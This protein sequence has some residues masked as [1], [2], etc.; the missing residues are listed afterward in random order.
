[1]HIK[2]NNFKRALECATSALHI[3]ENNQKAKFREAQ[4]R[5]GLGEIS[6]GRQMLEELQKK[7]P[8][9]AITNALNQLKLDEKARTQKSQSQFS[10]SS[11]FPSSMRRADLL[12]PTEGMYTKKPTETAAED[13][14]SSSSTSTAMKLPP[15]LDIPPGIAGAGSTSSATITELDADAEAGAAAAKVDQVAGADATEQPTAAG[16]EVTAESLAQA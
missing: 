8:D 2:Q 10:G 16:S 6:R 13:K 11:W 12:P 9:V 5:I 1:M 3:D 4:A 14:T 7:A 15:G